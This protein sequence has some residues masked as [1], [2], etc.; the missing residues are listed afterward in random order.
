LQGRAGNIGYKKNGILNAMQM[1]K[2]FVF[3]QKVLMK[4]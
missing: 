1:R 3:A 4:K 2:T